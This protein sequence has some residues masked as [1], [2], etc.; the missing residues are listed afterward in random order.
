VSL[1]PGTSIGKYTVLRKL[2]EGGMAELYLCSFAGPEG[3][4][5]D[6]VIKRIRPQLAQDPAFV[7]MFK[8]E[9]RLASRLNHRNV[10]QIFDFDRH[11]DTYYLAMEYVRG[12]SLWELRRR[13]R[14]QGVV[15]P[16]VLAAHLGAEVARGLA[17]AHRLKVDGQSLHLVHR[18]VTPHNVLLSYEGAVKLTDFGI[19]RAG[20][21]ATAP[22]VL[23][24]KFAYMSPEQA[25][26]EPVDARTDV[27]ALGIVLW[28]MLT[29]GKLFEGAGDAGVLRAVQQREIPPPA[30]LNP[31]VPEELDRAV[32]WALQRDLEAR[33][34]SAADLER[35]LSEA[36]LR[37]ARSVDD[38]DVGA[39]LRRVVPQQDALDGTPAPAAA[40]A[41]APPPPP[42]PAPPAVPREPTAVLPG[43]KLAPR[44]V[45]AEPVAQTF[46]PAAPE[47]LPGVAEPSSSARSAL[48]GETLP[49]EAQPTGSLAPTRLIPARESSAPLAVEASGV[50]PVT[51]RPA[52]RRAA[53]LAGAGVLLVTGL[54]AWR[55]RPPPASPPSGGAPAAAAPAQ[56]SP[57]AGALEA[58]TP[59]STEPA[60]GPTAEPGAGAAPTAQ[61]PAPVALPPTGTTPPAGEAPPAAPVVQP[62]AA[63]AVPGAG[64]PA[65][66][67]AEPASGQ[68]RVR[69]VPWAEVFVD[70]RS[71]G[72]VEGEKTFRLP[73][74]RHRVRLRRS[75]S[76]ALYDRPVTISETEPAVI[77][78]PKPAR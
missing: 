19:A 35:A 15:I 14:E 41:P 11:E 13:C 75:E 39:F 37:S 18:D 26:G 31:D 40:A 54:A 61:A 7:D 67:G 38:T 21:T 29:G 77:L 34:P 9:A 47:P 55:A 53:L 10:I 52:M 22:G 76:A 46:V 8:L 2:A 66:A 62:P 57:A 65:P 5:K 42:R 56:P 17:Y 72:Y 63:V 49:G 51:P 50:A 64:V 59:A 45:P 16:P 4:A 68:L 32:V 43:R 27:F 12:A 1:L 3:F 23:K 71:L 24:G 36:V 48:A 60:A 73:V 74:G 30:R 6:V 44:P 69:A 70:G 58:P 28:E 33:C 25:R 78:L 20:D